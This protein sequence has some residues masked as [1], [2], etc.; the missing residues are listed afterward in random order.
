MYPHLRTD[1]D[2]RRLPARNT[3]MDVLREQNPEQG[4]PPL[5]GEGYAKTH[6]F[7]GEDNTDPFSDEGLWRE[8]MG[9]A[10]KLLHEYQTSDFT[11]GRAFGV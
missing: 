5:N 10:L 6:E 3:D 2:D 4:F 8:C 1:E 7:L 9:E 11:G